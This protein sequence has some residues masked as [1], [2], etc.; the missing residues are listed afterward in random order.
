MP[1][2]SNLKGSI[3]HI[4]TQA[5]KP[6]HTQD[7]P[8]RVLMEIFLPGRHHTLKLTQKSFLRSC[9]SKK[10]FGRERERER[11]KVAKQVGAAERYTSSRE[12]EEKLVCVRVRIT[13]GHERALQL[14]SRAKQLRGVQ[15]TFVLIESRTRVQ[16]RQ[17]SSF[18]ASLPGGVTQCSITISH[19]KRGQDAICK[20]T[21]R[22]TALLLGKT[23]QNDEVSSSSFLL[24][25]SSSS[26]LP[27]SSPNSRTD[28]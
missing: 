28:R 19:S 20:S 8:Y 3:H 27:T 1:S 12:N 5:F 9:R 17:L 13:Q 11:E 24:L 2:R 16:E 22:V 4:N 21:S 6:A 18:R 10:G 14:G 26:S 23:E 7:Q 25:L 15:A